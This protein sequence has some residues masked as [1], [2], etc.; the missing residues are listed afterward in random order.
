MKLSYKH[1]SVFTAFS[2][3]IASIGHASETRVAQFRS[4]AECLI[5]V[6]KSSGQKLKPVTDKPGEV[7]GFLSNGKAFSCQKKETGTK[8]T[9]FEGWYMVN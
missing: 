9:Y 7:S 5:G 1:F 8:G 2:L 3:L 6:E 4:L